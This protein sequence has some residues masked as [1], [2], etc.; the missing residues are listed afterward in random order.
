[1]CL[2]FEKHIIENALKVVKELSLN[3]FKDDW[4]AM[5]VEKYIISDDVY[6]K[7]VYDTKLKRIVSIK[8]FKGVGQGVK[9]QGCNHT[10]LFDDF[11]EKTIDV[12]NDKRFI[13]Q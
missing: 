3:D 7:L 6:D 11:E 10:A 1:M 2:S 8:Y 13:I 4:G 9:L 12:S 5:Y